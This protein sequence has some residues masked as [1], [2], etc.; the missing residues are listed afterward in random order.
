MTK[1]TLYIYKK[2][3]GP[4]QKDGSEIWGERLIADA[5][6]ILQN[7]ENYVSVIDVKAGDA[8]EWIEVPE[9]IDFEEA[10]KILLGE[11]GEAE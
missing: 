6:Y 5:G 10:G 1:K 11:G 8:T 3:V 7:G 4:V 9:E 2:A